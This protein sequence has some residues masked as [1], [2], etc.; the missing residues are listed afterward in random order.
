MTGG[1]EI[2][3][4]GAVAVDTESLR[5]AAGGFDRAH[6]IAGDAR[7][8][9]VEVARLLPG[10][11]EGYGAQRLADE[12]DAVA[13]DAA[14]LAAGLRDTATVYDLVEL[15]AQ[16]AA[17]A[18]AG[19]AA[20]ARTLEGRLAALAEAAP[21]QAQLA[22]LLVAHRDDPHGELTRQLL[23]GALPYG[24]AGL[25]VISWAGLALLAVRTIGFGIVPAHR[26][27]GPARP[28][29]VRVPLLE[30][31]TAAAPTT[32]AAVATRLPGSGESRIRVERYTLPGG[33]HRF[34]V[35]IAG[36]QSVWGRDAF[37]MRANLQLASG[38]NAASYEAV[39][40]ALTAAGARAGDVVHVR[41]HSQGAMI[42]A[43][44]ALSGEYEVP[45]LVTFGSPVQADVGD[46]TLSVDVRHRDDPV[47]G[48][49]LG[50]HDAGVG[51][52]GSFVAE[53]VA[54]PSAGIHDL[55]FGAH[56][57]DAYAET[58]A[59]LD[60]STDPRMGAVRD[61]LAELAAAASVEVFVFGAERPGPRVPLGGGAVGGR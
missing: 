46:G 20:L 9:V 48:L 54:D 14:R 61:S 4:G 53:R 24:V 27:L 8:Y 49:A 47:S 29:D 3:S 42:G 28:P 12:A 21:A 16:R 31:S 1:L 43:H 38:R 26:R 57:L 22:E 19:D 5:H 32:L 39:R 23:L 13:S 41:G 30:R 25:A 35:Y 58:A 45:T 2:R 34:A 6:A 50:G 37:D 17:A 7:G 59:L 33:S 18:A 10:W 52:P 55:A 44:P 15:A 60:A 40:G 11:P 51:A 56:Q 36:T